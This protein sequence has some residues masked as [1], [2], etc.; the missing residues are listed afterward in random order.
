MVGSLYIINVASY[1]EAR[2]FIEGEPLNKAGL[3]ESM[4][5]RSWIQMQPEVTP[6]ANEL[7]AQELERDLI[8]SGS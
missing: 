3:F 8:A 4:M 6:G 2:E 1:D 5:V 7:T